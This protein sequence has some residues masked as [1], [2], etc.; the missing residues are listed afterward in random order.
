M[1]HISIYSIL[2]MQYNYLFAMQCEE[3]SS[4]EVQGGGVCRER[5]KEQSCPRMGQV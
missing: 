1:L 4:P 3:M 2:A 5:W